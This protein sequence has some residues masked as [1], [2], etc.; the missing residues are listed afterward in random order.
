V[1]DWIP[2]L[3]KS[4][5][6]DRVDRGCTPEDAHLRAER[7]ATWLERLTTSV[8]DR[9][10]CPDEPFIR[11]WRGEFGLHVGQATVVVARQGAGKSNTVSYLVERALEHRPEW[12]VYTNLPFPWDT[13]RRGVVPSPPRLFRVRSLSE[14]LR[15]ICQST[16]PAG[17]IP[18][19]F[20]DETDQS[21]TSH[22]WQG[23]DDESWMRFLYVERHF[24]VRGPMLVYHFYE[25]VPLPLRQ[26]GAL[27]GS[28]LRVVVRKGVRRLACVE[29]TSRW[30]GVREST[31]PY[32][33]LGLSG[34]ELDVDMKPLTATLNGSLQEMAAQA[35]EYLDRWEE[36]RKEQDLELLEAARE[37][38]ALSVAS[39]HD[40]VT[41]QHAARLQRREEIIQA[42]VE[43][44]D[45]TN[46][47]AQARF[48]AS[49]NYLTDLRQIAKV[50][51][52][53]AAGS[54][55]SSIRGAA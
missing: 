27:R 14:L 53:A 33:N 20:I 5:M 50:R 28:Y 18:A 9:A 37:R 49:P 11:Q 29:D 16:I 34:F 19:V 36:L 48:S 4:I 45:L 2:L 42:F 54:P 55:I 40:A 21:T 32:Y 44:P 7:Y 41:E 51:R 31:L 26:Q 23:T 22:T 30:F 6:D 17:R 1:T 25:H 24:R 8:H 10:T 47:V 39:T 3:A 38:H 46:V 12:D 35:V 15:Q 43:N 13:D 52:A